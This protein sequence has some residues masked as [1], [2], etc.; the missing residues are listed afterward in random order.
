MVR[1]ERENFSSAAGALTGGKLLAAAKP[2]VGAPAALKSPNLTA[3]RFC[4]T[5][6]NG[7]Q[8]GPYKTTSTM[9]FPRPFVLPLLSAAF[10]VA[11]FGNF[12]AAQ[13][14]P[15]FSFLTGP[16]PS[17]GLFEYRLDAGDFVRSHPAAA[18]WTLSVERDGTILCSEGHP[19]PGDGKAEGYANVGQMPDGAR[20]TITALIADKAGKE[21]SRQANVFTRKVMPFER[22]APLGMSDIIVPPFTAPVI[23]KN[24]VSCWERTYR[25]GPDGL[26]TGITAAGQPLLSRPARFLAR[27]GDGPVVALKGDEPQLS[28]VGKGQALYLQTFTGQG[29]TLKV[30]GAFDYDGFYKFTVQLSPTETPVQLADLC[31]ELPFRETVAQLIEASVSWRRI[32]GPHPE[33]SGELDTKQGVLWDSKTFPNRDWPR[34]GNMPPFFWVGDDDRG[35]VYSC[36]SEQGMHNDENL[37]AAQ[38]ERIRNEVVYTVWFVNSPLQLST[39]RTFQFA[40]QASPFKPMPQHSRLWRNQ[41]YRMPYK[42][43][44]LFTNWFTDGSYPTYGRF[45]SLDLLKKYADAT[46]AD[47]VGTMASSVSECGGTPEYLQFW[48]E[49]GSPLGWDQVTRRPPEEWAVKM[50]KEAGLPM[51]PLVR[52]ESASNVSRSNADYRAWWYNEELRHADIDY[53][54][55][56]NPPFVYYYDPPNGYGYIRDDCRKEP[57]SAIWNSRD[58][59]KRLATTAVEAGKPDSPYVWANVISPVL[60]GRSFCRKMLNGEYLYTRLFTLGQIRVMASKQWGMEL[61]WYPFPQTEESPYPNVGPVRKY[62]RAVFSRLLLHDITSFSGADDADFCQ[63]WLNALD[64]LWLDDPTLTWHP[65]YRTDAVQADHK[66]TYISTYTAKGRALLF[67]S[68]QADSG[69]VETVHTADLAR[70]GAADLKYF[71]DAET[72]E[73]IETGDALRL[74]IPGQDY[75]A[76][77]GLPSPWKYAAKVALGMPELP[78]QSALDPEDTLTAISLQL[79]KSPTLRPVA[80]ANRLY[81][82]WMKRVMAELSATSPDI[83]YRDASACSDIDFGKQGIQCSVFYYKKLDAMLLNYY[84]ASDADVSLSRNVRDLLARKAGKQGQGYVIHPVTGI[85]E[86]AFIDIPAH[87]GLLEVCYPDSVDYSRARNGPFQAGTMMANVNRAVE[88]RQRE[89][90]GRPPKK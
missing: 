17:K 6:R 32:D 31:L 89:M 60:P 74:F 30:E 21:L 8:C 35:L 36:A 86:W 14:T 73:E 28:P 26:L 87:R 16:Y 80:N 12:A 70:F 45:L 48:H 53:V 7:P 51:N 57:S 65:Y 76:V 42:D 77:L 39:E 69:T 13:T 11:T 58:F 10:L 79:L 38:L 40:L 9:L 41:G 84:N 72:G 68:N 61:D 85:S 18:T 29:I 82:E 19:L 83:A 66:T 50:L 54:Y 27:V 71:Y 24:Q 2:P 34:T 64:L 56:D 4:D 88:A 23:E 3:G 43:G 20:Y 78:A 46:G 37:P 62:W 15:A 63:R 67:I 52:V 25:H 90:G 55:Q 81:E 59:L 22:A 44:T 33:C 49:W 47:R 75:R 1:N 5:A